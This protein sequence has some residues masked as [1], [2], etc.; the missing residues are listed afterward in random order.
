MPLG[1]TPYVY[2]GS[3]EDWK[4]IFY[5]DPNISMFHSISVP[6]G[7][8]VIKAGTV[9]GIITESTNRKNYYVPY[10]PA[11]TTGR[12]TASLS[13]D[14]ARGLAYMVSDQGGAST[15]IYVGMDDSYMFAVGDHVATIDSDGVD[16]DA[17][18][19]TAIDRT[20]YSHMAKI[21]V[22]NTIAAITTAKG[23]CVFIQSKAAAPHVE[24]KGILLAAV[25]TGTGENAKG[26]NGVIVLRNA[27][28]YKNNL[29]CY[30]SDALDDLSNAAEDGKYLVM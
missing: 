3:Q 21:T 24:A 14:E 2:Q 25:D 8:G 15:D 19:I 5:S 29:Y 12:V 13:D 6:A 11:D 4:R 16:D 23:A 1:Q 7:F 27:M 18:A 17:G 10:V 26:G 9:M 28:V 20:T 30:N 22:T